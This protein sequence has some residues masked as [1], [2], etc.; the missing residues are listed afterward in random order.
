LE[1]R[2]DLSLSLS[3]GPC[4]G[5]AYGATARI[6]GITLV[7]IIRSYDVKQNVCRL[8]GRKA[9]VKTKEE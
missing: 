2:G 5:S 8:L 9:H 3:A 1:E 6:D 4:R 7:V